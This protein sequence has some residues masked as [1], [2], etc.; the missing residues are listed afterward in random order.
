MEKEVLN[1]AAVA[2]GL[3]GYLLLAVVEVGQFPGRVVHLGL[4]CSK[5][6]F[7]SFLEGR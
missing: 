4:G 7:V 6:P 2:V 1:F 5:I 3:P